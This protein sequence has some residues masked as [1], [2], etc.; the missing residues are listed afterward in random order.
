LLFSLSSFPFASEASLIFF[1]KGMLGDRFSSRY[2]EKLKGS[3]AVRLPSPYGDATRTAAAKLIAPV[4]FIAVSY[5]R[6]SLS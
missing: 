2:S 1:E 5:L 6:L 4:I 3:Q